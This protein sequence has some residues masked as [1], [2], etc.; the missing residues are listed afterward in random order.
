[1]D[2]ERGKRVCVLLLCLGAKGY[3]CVIKEDNK[4]PTFLNERKRST[5]NPFGPFKFLA[6]KF[7][8]EFSH[9]AFFF[10]FFLLEKGMGSGFFFEERRTFDRRRGRE[11]GE[12]VSL[13]CL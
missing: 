8:L 1:M 12:C 7:P 5:S 2:L 4:Q 6:L 11:K 10:F 3:I 13:S 9:K